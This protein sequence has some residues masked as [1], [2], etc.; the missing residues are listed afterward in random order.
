MANETNPPGLATQTV[1]LAV[2]ANGQTVKVQMLPNQVIEV[3][4]DMTEANVTLVDDALH[5]EFSGGAVLILTDF[6]VMVDQ[7]VSPLMLF[8]DG[9]VVAGDILLTVLTADLPGTADG[10]G[11][12]S[13]VEPFDP[14]PH[15]T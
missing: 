1:I 3:P 10:C 15:A 4:F 12:G 9:S 6:A 7:G 14:H 8:A 13:G 5:I 11:V 2:P